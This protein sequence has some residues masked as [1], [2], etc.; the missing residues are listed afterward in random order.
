MSSKDNSTQEEFDIADKEYEQIRSE[1]YE[2][3]K[4]LK[5]K[6]QLLIEKENITNIINFE[7]L[8]Q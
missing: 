7:K 8:F 3:R 5:S 1:V 6:E 2:L 4:L